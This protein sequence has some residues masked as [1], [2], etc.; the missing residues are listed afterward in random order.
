MVL[1]AETDKMIAQNDIPKGNFKKYLIISEL[2]HKWGF[3]INDTGY[4]IYPK[5]SEYPAKGHPGTYMFF[6]ENTSGAGSS[7][8]HIRFHDEAIFESNSAGICTIRQNDA[9]FY[10]NGSS[11]E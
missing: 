5:D 6:L 9:F 10:S 7:S 3:I 11:T 8:P 1:N 2:D 4:A